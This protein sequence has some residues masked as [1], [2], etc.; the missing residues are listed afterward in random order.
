MVLNLDKDE[1]IP[2]SYLSNYQEYYG[3]ES[4]DG[5]PLPSLRDVFEDIYPSLQELLGFACDSQETLDLRRGYIEGCGS[6]ETRY[7]GI[8]EE[9]YD[10]S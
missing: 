9:F 1:S 5:V 2:S 3:G 10:E 4:Q 6:G 7:D 8:R